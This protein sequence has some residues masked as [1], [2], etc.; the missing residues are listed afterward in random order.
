M[1]VEH[2]CRPDVYLWVRGIYYTTRGLELGT[3]EPA[4]QLDEDAVGEMVG[5]SPRPHRRCDHYISSFKREF[6]VV[7]PG[8]SR[9]SFGIPSLLMERM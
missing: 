5:F 7:E 4:W 9:I 6:L 8:R 1:G 2:T 3:L